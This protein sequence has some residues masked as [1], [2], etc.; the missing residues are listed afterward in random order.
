LL[1]SLLTPLSVFAARKPEKMLPQ[2]G[3]HLVFAFGEQA[4]E[5]INA[6]KII[7]DQAPLAAYPKDLQQGVVRNRSRLNL[8]MVVRVDPRALSAQTTAYAT[9]GLVAYSAV[10]THTGCTVEG[11]N[12]G[13]RRMICPCHGSEYDAADAARVTFGPAPKPLAMLP[14]TVVDDALVISGGFSRRVGFQQ[15]NR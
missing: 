5:S 13:T 10:C 14:L 15:P 8:V 2:P 3:D 9:D 7:V 4:G 1:T 11:W 6:S 12:A